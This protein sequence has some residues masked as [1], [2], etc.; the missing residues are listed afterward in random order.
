M[1][2][3]VRE[4]RL[5]PRQ[6]VAPMFVQPGR[7][8]RSPVGSMPGVM[9]VTPDEALRDARALAALGIGGV[10]LFGLPANKDAI[11][12]GGWVADGSLRWRE[13]VVDG[14]D[15]AVDA[16]LGLHRGDNTGKMLVRL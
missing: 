12:T 2:A 13:T 15:H 7:E 5:H 3:F 9:R 11:G 14:L 4:T 8:G 1:R 10:I 16:F 6:L